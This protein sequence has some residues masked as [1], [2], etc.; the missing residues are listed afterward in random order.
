MVIAGDAIGFEVVR[1]AAVAIL[2]GLV[3]SIA[4]TLIVLPAAY[5][6][7]GF[8]AEPDLSGEELLPT[9]DEEPTRIEPSVKRGSCAAMAAAAVAA[10]AMLLAGCAE[11][12][13]DDHEVVEPVVLESAGADL[14]RITLTEH[15]AE[16]LDIQTAPVAAEGGRTVIPSDAWFVQDDGS[17]WVYVSP[18][19]L[20]FVRHGISIESDD[21]THA[22]LTAGPPPGTQVVTVGV[23]ELLGAESEIG[24]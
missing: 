21:G 12:A 14:M 10:T 3:T 7:Y 6:R 11:T 24:H 23:P 1:P 9:L 4:L 15:A 19:P 13:S 8:V 5:L 18:E 2:G 16:R 20:V 17:L 22:V